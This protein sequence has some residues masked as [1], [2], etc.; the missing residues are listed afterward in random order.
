MPLQNKNTQK[1]NDDQ[2]FVIN[3]I[4]KIKAE[5]SS[6]RLADFDRL[7]NI[8]TNLLAM[9]NIPP[10]L[11]NI[12]SDLSFKIAAQE[13]QIKDTNINQ[14]GLTEEQRHNNADLN[15]HFDEAFVHEMHEQ[16]IQ[17]LKKEYNSYSAD[18]LQELEHDNK[19]L[20][21]ALSGKE[22]SK[23]EQAKL[24]GQHDSADEKAKAEEKLATKA[25]KWE[26]IYELEEK[27]TNSL[28]YKQEKIA[29]FDKML[30]TTDLPHEK[31]KELIRLKIKH[32]QK[33]D[34]HSKTLNAIKTKCAKRDKELELLADPK[35]DKNIAHHLI[36]KHHHIHNKRYE[37]EGS[38]NPDHCGLKTLKR[39]VKEIDIPDNLSKDHQA[40]ELH[41]S[42]LKSKA[43][44]I[45]KTVKHVHSLK[46]EDNARVSQPGH[47]PKISKPTTKGRHD[48]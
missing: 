5:I 42:K 30:A 14:S 45:T 20:E 2:A 21:K 18:M 15:K 33:I 6:L 17:S 38:I 41:A 47:T 12:V 19:L 37:R 32:Q 10:A 9:P 39:L 23:N 24:T 43:Q 16:K 11:R 4:N 36:K 27:L 29:Q 7:H 44:N 3:E 22:L 26:Q 13:Q 31:Q 1:P 8:I 48:I 34:K 28:K 25:K 46:L 40:K 35:L